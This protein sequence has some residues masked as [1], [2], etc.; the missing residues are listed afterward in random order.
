MHVGMNI[1]AFMK[2]LVPPYL[3][4]QFP[5][6]P[7]KSIWRDSFFSKPTGQSM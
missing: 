2:K 6:G 3:S 7:P 4:D 5:A 1:A